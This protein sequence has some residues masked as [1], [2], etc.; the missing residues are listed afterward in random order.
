[1]RRD[2]EERPSPNHGERRSGPTD[3]LMLHYTGM[4]DCEGAIR[5]LC[6]PESQVS[7]H[8][9]VRADGAIVRL[10]AEDRRAWHAGA[11]SWAG[12]QD[13]NSRSIGIEICNPGHDFGAPPFPA[14]QIAAVIDLCR[15]ILT[16]HPIPPERVLAHSD[17]APGR[18]RDPGEWFPWTQLAAAGIGQAVEPVPIGT[19]AGLTLGDAGDH[20]MRLQGD[21][22]A[23]G[24][25]ITASGLY[26]RGTAD[27]V[28]A[29][30]RHFRP[31]RVDGIADRST[32]VTLARLLDAL[33]PRVA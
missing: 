26:D 8:Y 7:C 12:A 33:G 14:E 31:E 30:Q 21:L 1:M 18:K 9:V 16:R 28:A 13:V 29:F 27:V 32:V 24:Y 20:V 6:L 4:P 3:I 2:I 10:V 25:G 11:G 17:T 22:A 15:D 5:W 19:D 23:Y